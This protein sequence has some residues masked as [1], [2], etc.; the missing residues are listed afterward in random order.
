MTMAAQQGVAVNEYDLGVDGTR[1][2]RVNVDTLF[3]L[4]QLD[5]KRLVTLG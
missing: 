4:K 5:N 2:T 1:A 3:G